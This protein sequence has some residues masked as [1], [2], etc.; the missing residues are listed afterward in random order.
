MKPP[1]QAL[2]RKSSQAETERSQSPTFR[3]RLGQ[4]ERA[5]SLPEPKMVCRFAGF[6]GIGQN[7]QGGLVVPARMSRCPAPEMTRRES[8]RGTSGRGL[9]LIQPRFPQRWIQL[10]DGLR[11]MAGG[12]GGTGERR[13]RSR[14]AE[15]EGAVQALCWNCVCG[16]LLAKGG[17]FR[18]HHGMNRREQ[19]FQFSRIAAWR[20]WAILLPAGQIQCREPPQKW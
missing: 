7:G 13:G 18:D 4:P 6:G 9:S 8:G 16:R 14:G 10:V 19:D 12:R 2:E 17:A 11:Q 5:G 20:D 1:S 3:V 15:V